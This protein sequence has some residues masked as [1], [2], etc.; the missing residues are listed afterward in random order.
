MSIVYVVKRFPKYSET[1][2]RNEIQGLLDKGVDVRVVSLE[3]PH[4]G[5]PSVEEVSRFA[6]RITYLHLNRFANLGV[7]ALRR[8]RTRRWWWRCLWWCVRTR[9]LSHMRRLDEATSLGS[10][11]AMHGASRFHAHFAHGPATTAMIAGDLTGTAFSFTAHA[12][13]LYELTPRWLL[14]EKASRADFIAVV[15][16]I[17]RE[18]LLDIGV[19]EMKVKVVR[20]GVRLPTPGKGGAK[21]GRLV[22][23]SV[24]RFVPKKGHDVL[25]RALGLLA[26]EGLDFEARLVGGG[27]QR[28][29]LEGL[30][31]RL[32]L[33][34]QVHFLDELPAKD[35]S[36]E[37]RGADIFA[38]ACRVTRSGDR[39]GLPVA[40]VEAMAQ[41]L[42]VVSTTVSAIPEAITDGHDGLL[43]PPDDPE[44]LAAA[45]KRLV[46]EPELRSCLGARASARAARTFSPQVATESLLALFQA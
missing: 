45:L 10:M 30:A 37:L 3:R 25:L 1:F 4:P 19:D 23:L 6:G 15:G 27:P 22:V 13:D 32:R 26:A 7:G 14:R 33:N 17:H 9:S 41:G 46:G 16:D 31:H 34:G 36:Q 29:A 39:D 20:N 28:K 44:Q 5:D 40:L 2:I 18:Y 8:R 21:N 43:V 24:G 12:R 42:P 38:L 11:A 35:V